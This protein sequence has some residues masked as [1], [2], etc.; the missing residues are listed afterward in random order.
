MSVTQSLLLAN[1]LSAFKGKNNLNF[2][3]KIRS[4]FGLDVLEFKERKAPDGDDFTS[5]SQLVSV[6]KQISDKVYL[7][8]DQ[9]VSGD[10]GTTAT[11]QLDMTPSLK[12]EADVGGDKNTA[13]GFSWVKKY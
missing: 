13:L 7:S 6:G 4:A 11:V 9:S 12:I 2:T 10:G 3:D 1:A 8:V 5:A